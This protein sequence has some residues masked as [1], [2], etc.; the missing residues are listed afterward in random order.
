MS[1]NLIIFTSFY[2]SIEINQFGFSLK[3]N[4]CRFLSNI[5]NVK[6]YKNAPE[7]EERM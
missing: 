4:K 7:A 2:W 5:N 6:L 1:K 3:N